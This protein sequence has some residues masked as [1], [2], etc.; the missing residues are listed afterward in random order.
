[1]LALVGTLSVSAFISPVLKDQGGEEK[2]SRQATT[3][4]LLLK[5][6]LMA[7]LLVLLLFVVETVKT[8]Y[9]AIGFLVAKAIL[10]FRFV[11]FLVN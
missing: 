1:M 5:D 9:N 4:N 8:G 6:V 3:S 7:P 2:N 10:G 11:I